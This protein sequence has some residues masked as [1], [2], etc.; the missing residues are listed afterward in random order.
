M[1]YEKFLKNTLGKAGKN[2]CV[3]AII[4]AGFI[5]YE[6]RDRWKAL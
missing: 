3:A 2:G 4:G 1:G 5:V 6:I